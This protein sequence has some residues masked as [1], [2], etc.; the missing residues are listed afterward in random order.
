[1]DEALPIWGKVRLTVVAGWVNEGFGTVISARMEG[2]VTFLGVVVFTVGIV[3]PPEA[4]TAQIPLSVASV[5]TEYDIPSLWITIVPSRSV[6]YTVT[7]YLFRR[8]SVSLCG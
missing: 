2:R 6:R 4:G 3:P 7:P 8:S 5:F 1:M